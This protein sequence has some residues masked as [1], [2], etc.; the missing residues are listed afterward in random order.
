MLTVCLPNRAIRI[1]LTTVFS[2]PRAQQYSD[3]CCWVSWD[4]TFHTQVPSPSG[5]PRPLLAR[6]YP[7]P[8]CQGCCCQNTLGCVATL[9]LTTCLLPALC[10][11]PTRRLRPSACALGRAAGPGGPRLSVILET[12]N[13]RQFPWVQPAGL[14]EKPNL[15][16]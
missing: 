13:P 2:V 10:Q 8:P 15:G 1:S 3:V 14:R 7:S 4:S 9:S 12:S 5:E 16:Q 11:L 6:P